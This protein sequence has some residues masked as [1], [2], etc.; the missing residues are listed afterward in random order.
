MRPLPVDSYDALAGLDGVVDPEALR[1]ALPSAL[2]GFGSGAIM[3]LAHQVEQVQRLVDTPVKRMVAAGGLGILGGLGIW[4]LD[5]DAAM[6]WVGGMSA[7]LASELIALVMRKPGGT[8]G[9]GAYPDEDELDAEAALMG[10]S[11]LGALPEEQ[12]LLGLGDPAVERQ[13]PTGFADAEIEV[14]E[15]LDTSLAGFLT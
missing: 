8:A 3:H 9:L 11:Y 13:T 2:G 15:E 12:E 5:R 14:D 7:Q 1:A 6:G 4:R 10:S